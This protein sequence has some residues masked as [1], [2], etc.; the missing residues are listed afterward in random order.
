MSEKV[1]KIDILEED[2]DDFEEFEEDGNFV[3]ID[4]QNT[5][6]NLE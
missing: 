6:Q 4:W 5:A 1:P 2:D 3:I